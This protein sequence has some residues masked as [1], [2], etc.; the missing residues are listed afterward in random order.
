MIDEQ[1][2]D[3]TGHECLETVNPPRLHP[4]PFAVGSGNDEG[5]VFAKA[6][7]DD[8]GFFAAHHIRK[9]LA[10]GVVETRQ[11]DEVGAVR[12][13]PAHR[14]GGKF[15]RACRARHVS[16]FNPAVAAGDHAECGDGQGPVAR[17]PGCE[18]SHQRGLM[19]TLA[20]ARNTV[21]GFQMIEFFA[22]FTNER[23]PQ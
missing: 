16:D 10:G 7:A 23:R 19:L 21:G 15:R 6:V 12:Q 17:E 5:G 2:E 11:E 4:R 8:L 9:G 14:A 1:V 22:A 13:R 20:K 3:F 18:C